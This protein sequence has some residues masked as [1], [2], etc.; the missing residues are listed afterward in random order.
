MNNKSFLRIDLDH[1]KKIQCPAPSFPSFA[2]K[3]FNKLSEKGYL[4]FWQG[5]T[6]NGFP[7]DILIGHSLSLG[8]AEIFLE[9]VKI[10][11]ELG[12]T[13]IYYETPLSYY[14]V[15]LE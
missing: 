9:F 11:K 5:S 4:V 10:I 14:P 12:V 6:T 7:N 15:S 8:R 13:D 1:R 2:E 3:L